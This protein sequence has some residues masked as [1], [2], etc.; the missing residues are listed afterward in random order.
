VTKTVRF[1]AVDYL[2]GEECQVDYIAAALEADWRINVRS[3]SKSDAKAGN[4]RG[5]RRARR[6]LQ[7]SSHLSSEFAA[8]SIYHPA[9]QPTAHPFAPSSSSG[10]DR[11]IIA[12]P[13]ALS[14][15]QHRRRAETSIV[16]SCRTALPRHRGPTIYRRDFV[17]WRF[18]AAG[19]QSAWLDRVAGGRKPAK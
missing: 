3:S 15:R 11:K 18:S 13:V 12:T 2:D 4:E 5:P 19:R 10:L 8:R 16:L 6:P 14:P 7:Q 1:D 17:P 9:A